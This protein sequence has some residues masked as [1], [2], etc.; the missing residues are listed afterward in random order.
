M[1]DTI[2]IGLRIR[3]ARKKHRLSQIEFGEALGLSGDAIS[4][5]E[6]GKARV[7]E[8]TI[9]AIAQAHFISPQWLRSGE[10]HMDIP[11]AENR[12]EEL[13]QRLCVAIGAQELLSA[14]FCGMGKEGDDGL[15]RS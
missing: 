2:E 8:Q 5:L 6:T 15:G 13:L 9:L 4:R 1:T 3:E 10:G 14:V 7:T 12:A 11:Q